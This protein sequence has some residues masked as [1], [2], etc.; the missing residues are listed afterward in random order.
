MAGFLQSTRQVVSWYGK[1]SVQESVAQRTRI[2]LPDW[3]SGR[4]PKLP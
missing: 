4:S 3:E 2:D 1:K